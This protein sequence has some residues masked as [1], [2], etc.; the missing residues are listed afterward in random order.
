[1]GQRVFGELG[2]RDEMVKRLREPKS[3]DG[4]EGGKGDGSLG[5]RV[6]VYIREKVWR[7]EA[8]AVQRVWWVRV[9]GSGRTQTGGDSDSNQGRSLANGGRVAFVWLWAWAWCVHCVCVV[10]KRRNSTYLEYSFVY[11]SCGKASI[12]LSSLPIHC[13][14]ATAVTGQY[15]RKSYGSA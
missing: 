15:G 12:V 10:R 4:R 13:A 5:Q 1:M 9:R 7:K 8:A 14:T 2:Q 11:G 3:G 6:C